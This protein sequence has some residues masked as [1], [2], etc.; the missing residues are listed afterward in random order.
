MIRVLRILEYIYETPERAEEDLSNWGVAANGSHNFGDLVVK[1]A[2]IT[3]LVFK[4][5]NGGS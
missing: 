5:E 4:G 3:D 2:I 1:S